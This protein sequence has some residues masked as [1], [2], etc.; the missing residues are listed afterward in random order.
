[1]ENNV[2]TRA[3]ISLSQRKV[4]TGDGKWEGENYNIGVLVVVKSHVDNWC[5]SKN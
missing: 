5:K 3:T 1:M 4:K 2:K